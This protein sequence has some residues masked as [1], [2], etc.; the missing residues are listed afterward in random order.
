MR[1]ILAFWVST[2]AAGS[3]ARM[4]T[5]EAHGLAEA[6]GS[7]APELLDA[8]VESIAD[9]VYLVGP[10]GAVA[11]ANRAALEILGYPDDAELVGRPSHDAIHSRR[12]DGSAFPEEECPLLRPRVT[13]ETVRID[14]DWFVRRDGTMVP[15]A[16]SSAPVGTADGRGAVVV[17]RDVSDRLEAQR[18]RDREA[19]ERG[20][21]DEMGASRARIAAAADEERRRLSRDLHDG[22]QQRLT[23]VLLALRQGHVDDA[24]AETRG[25]IE[26]LRDFAAGLHPAILTLRGLAAAIE[27]LTARAQLPVTLDLVDERM[28]PAV[29]ATAYFLIAEALANVAKHADATSA[30]VRTAIADGRLLIDVADDGRGG[31]DPAA[32]T[33][34][35]G[36]ADRAAAAG[37]T[38][39]IESPPGAGTHVHAELPLAP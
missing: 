27:S 37:G 39:A 9:G 4:S 18:A 8:F 38:L 7:A 13:G 16:Y 11:F 15:V 31:A 17:F 19:L 30:S 22:A 28:P 34:L 29:E 21:A 33:G 14:E 5:G 25:A 36:L 1:T 32:G 2:P 6:I 24:L 26:D 12:P 20:R 3:V 10:D 35:R 23:T